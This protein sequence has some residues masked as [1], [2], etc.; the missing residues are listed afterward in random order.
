[1]IPLILI[2]GY[3]VGVMEPGPGR[4]KVEADHGAEQR[5]LGHGRHDCHAD[6]E[7][8]HRTSHGE[9]SAW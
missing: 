6:P 1:M 3:P 2:H 4:A 9:L 5:A 8:P 7:W